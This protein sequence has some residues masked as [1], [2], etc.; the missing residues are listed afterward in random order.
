MIIT[1]T[2]FR[3]SFCG[4][5]SDLKSFYE[6]HEGCVVSATV[7]K[8]MYVSIHPYFDHEK[9]SLKYSKNELVDNVDD[10]EH[11]I[12]REALKQFKI[13]GVEIS[14]VAD[15]PAGTGLGSSSA[16]TVGALNALSAYAGESLSKEELAENAC[17]IEINRLGSPIGKQD[18]Y[19]A[20]FGGL[21]FIRFLPCGKTLVEPIKVSDETLRKLERRL[22][23]FY[24]G[25]T[26][27][28]DAI[29]CEQ[30]KNT[31]RKDGEESLKRMCVLAQELK[32]SLELG[33]VD[34][35]GRALHENWRLKRTLAASI[36]DADL[37]AIYETALR[38]GALGGKLLGAGGGGFFLFYC[39]E[40]RQDELRNS[41][42]LRD[43]PFRFETAG[44]TVVFRDDLHA[45]RDATTP[46]VDVGAR[47]R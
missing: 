21:N 38:H 24:T 15:V 29:L 17:D 1:R 27:N 37:D 46:L 45:R 47:E 8:Y 18:Q 28:A 22:L 13:K 11:R 9:I 2:P 35:F 42:G 20:A 36:A 39:E 30:K 41:L 43:F 33:E 16:F 34:R 23:M 7:D 25:R 6:L 32:E 12:L 10:V 5:G 4:G 31:S 44:T 19:A 14:S 3:I 40:E 26:H